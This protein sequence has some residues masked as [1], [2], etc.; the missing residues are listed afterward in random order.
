MFKNYGVRRRMMYVHNGVQWCE[1]GS[2][3][4]GGGVSRPRIW[5]PRN[6]LTGLEIG[7]PQTPAT[8]TLEGPRG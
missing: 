7:V 3:V 8:V 2:S 5:Y 4:Q 6:R 1:M